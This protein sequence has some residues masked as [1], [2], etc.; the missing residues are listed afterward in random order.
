MLKAFHNSGKFLVSCPDD[1]EE[2]DIHNLA[3]TT[4]DINKG[5]E[6]IINI[7]QELNN[8]FVDEV[9]YFKELLTRYVNGDSSLLEELKPYF[10]TVLSIAEISF[11]YLSDS[12]VEKKIEELIN[13]FGGNKEE[14]ILDLLIKF[15]LTRGSC[16]TGRVG[17]CVGKMA[18]L[19]FL[20]TLISI[21]KNFCD[22]YVS[23]G[24]IWTLYTDGMEINEIRGLSWNMGDKDRTLLL[25]FKVPITAK[26]IDFVLL[27]VSHKNIVFKQPSNN[28]NV[29]SIDIFSDNMEERTNGICITSHLDENNCLLI[30]EIK[31]ITKPHH[32][33][34]FWREAYT[35]MKK[36]KITIEKSIGKKIHSVLISSI[37][38][39]SVIKYIYEELNDGS[40]SYAVNLSKDAHVE[41]FCEW[42][43]K[44]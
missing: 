31:N 16:R 19:K 6:N 7:S 2:I 11:K 43:L 20:K 21:L 15:T 12:F 9:L 8:S 26:N 40:L 27:K 25:N 36:H 18:E 34:V 14:V 17:N 3:S 5:Y 23:Y 30:G 28:K 33:A 38:D 29:E 37:I 41:K 35:A 42:L 4:E 13:S 22:I 32:A 10:L 44:K 24:G 1:I 39:K